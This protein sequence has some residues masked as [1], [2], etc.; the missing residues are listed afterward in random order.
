[1]NK[2]S[3][4]R[5]RKKRNSLLKYVLLLTIILIVSWLSWRTWGNKKQ[6]NPLPAVEQIE[7]VVDTLAVAADSVKNTESTESLKIAETPAGNKTQ[8]PAEAYPELKKPR[9]L[10]EGLYILIVKNR[11]ELQLYRDGVK[12]KTYRVGLGKYPEDKAAVGDMR[13]PEGHFYINF[14]RDS[15]AWT[16]DFKDGKGETPGAYGPWF[17]ALYTGKQNTFSQKTWTGIGIHGT[18]DPNTIG[19]NDS[20]GCIRMY[21][22]EVQEL[23][24]IIGK[25]EFVAVDIVAAL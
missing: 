3:R 17:M 16:H 12:S 10:K 19:K 4:Y 7:N 25:N 18:H 23:R 22:N 9:M 20:E 21:N 2:L 11:H 8:Q 1:M 5:Q 15:R 13:T 24:E 14:I 6:Q